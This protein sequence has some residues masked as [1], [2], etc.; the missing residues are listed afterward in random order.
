MLQGVR[1][2]VVSQRVHEGD[3]VLIAPWVCE[4]EGIRSLDGVAGGE[5]RES[6]DELFFFEDEGVRAA[7]Q[8][9]RNLHL[10][11]IAFTAG[12]VVAER[13]NDSVRSRLIGGLRRSELGR[14]GSHFGRYRNREAS[15]K[16]YWK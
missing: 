7:E 6:V 16:C 12:F 13:V 5:V 11:E 9:V 8:R 4:L 3:V 1:H 15:E 10:P 14:A 2:F